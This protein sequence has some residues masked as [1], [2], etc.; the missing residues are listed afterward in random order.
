MRFLFLLAVLFPTI[1]KAQAPALPKSAERSMSWADVKRLEE[2]DGSTITRCGLIKG[3][4]DDNVTGEPGYYKPVEHYLNGVVGSRYDAKNDITYSFEFSTN[5]R[6][7]DDAKSDIENTKDFYIKWY[8]DDE[9][10]ASYQVLEQLYEAIIDN[11]HLNDAGKYRSG[12]RK[13]KIAE[14]SLR[15]AILYFNS[16]DRRYGLIF[17]GSFESSAYNPVVE[18]PKYV[19]PCAEGKTVSR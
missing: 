8:S 9:D 4:V 3:Y 7:G 16:K 15:Q 13:G 5:V 2:A 10:E 14:G 12:N 17:K 19:K 6:R 11:Y 18:R 1:L